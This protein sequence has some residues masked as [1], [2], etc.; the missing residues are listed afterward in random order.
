MIVRGKAIGERVK[1]WVRP[2][3]INR[4]NE[5]SIKAYFDSEIVK[6]E[7]DKLHFRDQNNTIHSIPNDFVLAL[8]G[9]QP[10][11]SFIQKIG[12]KLSDDPPKTYLQSANYGDEC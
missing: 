10:N 11:F 8:T 3:V 7:K 4:I 2:D 5:G 1:Y 6:I 12:V 9:Y